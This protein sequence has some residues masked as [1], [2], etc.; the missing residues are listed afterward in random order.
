MWLLVFE[1]RISRRV[2]SA[3]NHW[4]ISP[5]PRSNFKYKYAMIHDQFCS[6]F[7]KFASVL[8]KLK[9]QP[10]GDIIFK[11]CITGGGHEHVKDLLGGQRTTCGKVILSFPYMSSRDQSHGTRLGS[12]H[13]CQLIPVAQVSIHCEEKGFLGSDGVVGTAHSWVDS[14]ALTRR[15]QELV[16]WAACQMNLP[17]PWSWTFLCAVSWP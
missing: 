14:V 4:A 17:M 9:L 5:A 15:F 11:I 7:W 2:A 8:S 1:L 3:L 13:F 6:C 16:G 10:Q 12:W